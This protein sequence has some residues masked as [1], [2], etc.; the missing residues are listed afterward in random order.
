MAII[1]PP[2]SPA[3]TVKVKPAARIGMTRSNHVCSQTTHHH[4]QS[5]HPSHH[6]QTPQPKRP[7]ERTMLCSLQT[8]FL[9]AR[10]G[11]RPE[12]LGNSDI[13]P[14]QRERVQTPRCLCLEPID[15]FLSYERSELCPASLTHC[16]SASLPVCQTL[17]QH[18]CSHIG[19]D[20]I[21]TVR[22]YISSF[23]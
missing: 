17:G 6:R 9:E 5:I 20:H 7:S 23:S 4:H 8:R 18:S 2:A 16:Q 10:K 22:S 11:T 13:D 14:L 3:A 19:Q 1:S 15:S 12:E 21:S